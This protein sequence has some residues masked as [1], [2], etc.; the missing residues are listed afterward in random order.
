MRDIPTG[1][2]SVSAESRIPRGDLHFAP[3]ISKCVAVRVSLFLFGQQP[4][5]IALG[6]VNEGVEMAID[7]LGRPPLEGDMLSGIDGFH[8]VDGVPRA[9]LGTVLATNATVKIDIAPGLK[10]GMIF[11]RHFID[12]IYRANFQTGSHPVQPSAWMTARTL[13]IT[14]R[15]LPARDAAAMGSGPRVN[16]NASRFD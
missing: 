5:R 15:G 4:F 14:F 9:D 1:R 7:V 2:G 3:V 8:H 11:A 6:G 10:A 16:K 12:T 13:G